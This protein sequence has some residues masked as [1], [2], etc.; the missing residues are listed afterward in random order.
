MTAADLTGLI[1]RHP[2]GF[3]CGFISVICGI[4]LY[5]RSGNI[6]NSQKELEA[7]MAQVALMSANIRNAAGLSEQLAEVQSLTKEIDTRIMK[8]SQLAVNLQYFYKLET[9]N[10]VKLLDVR[11]GSFPRNIKTMYAGVPFSISIQGP[12]SNVMNFLNR[13]QHGRHFCRIIT[14]SFTKASGPGDELSLSINL[15]LLGQP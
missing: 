9:E 4:L 2:I 6:E 12:Y 7:S 14:T 1:K 5:L 3:A 10:E 15:E 8:A 11:Q 13:L